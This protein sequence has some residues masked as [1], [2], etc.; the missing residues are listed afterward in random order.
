MKLEEKYIFEVF[1][2]SVNITFFPMHFLGLAGMP[3]RIPDY[4]DVYILWNKIASFGSIL[5]FLS[6]LFFIIIIL[7]SFLQK[8]NTYLY[9]NYWEFYKIRLIYLKKRNKKL[10]VIILHFMHTDPCIAKILVTKS[11]LTNDLKIFVKD[12]YYN[13]GKYYMSFQSYDLIE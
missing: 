13:R 1:F 2:A 11:C 8:P 3:R 9:A 5:S 7:D 12:N 10:A 6:F 4:P